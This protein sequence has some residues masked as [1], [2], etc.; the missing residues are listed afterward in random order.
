MIEIVSD[1]IILLIANPNLSTIL[2]AHSIMNRRYNKTRVASQLKYYQEGVM[3]R[4][5]NNYMSH[6]ITRQNFKK[7]DRS[8]RSNISDRVNMVSQYDNY[9]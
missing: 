9:K 7:N 6:I 4:K 2:P 1:F 5:T 8:S 3:S